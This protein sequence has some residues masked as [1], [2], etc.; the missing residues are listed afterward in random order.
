MTTISRRATTA[1]SCEQMYALVSDVAAYREF[2]PWCDHSSVEGED[3]G[4][5]RATLH[6]K[7]K[8]MGLSLTTLNRNLPPGAIEMELA[9]GPFRHLRG[10][11]TFAP[12]EGGGCTV[13]LEMDFDFSNRVYAGLLKPVFSRIAS[14]LVDAFTQRAREVYG[15]A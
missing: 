8:G 15:Q 11:W 7:H 12:L 13:G 9:E 4:R 2:L 5:V 10:K 1:Y 3:R 14:S 6:L